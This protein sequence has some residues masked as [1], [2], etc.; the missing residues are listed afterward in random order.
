MEANNNN[1]SD[2]NSPLTG[3]DNNDGRGGPSG[4]WC[5]FLSVSVAVAAA[6]AA[7]GDL[8]SIRFS[9]LAAAARSFL[10]ICRAAGRPR[11]PATSFILAPVQTCAQLRPGTGKLRQLSLCQR[12]QQ[13]VAAPTT[14]KI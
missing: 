6:A 2:T 5:R 10:T 1:N 8:S 11:T 12:T 3:H 9:P 4:Q 14:L 7:A 13:L